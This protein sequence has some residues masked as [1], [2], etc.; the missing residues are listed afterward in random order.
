M[1]KTNLQR[2]IFAAV[3][4]LYPYSVSLIDLTAEEDLSTPPVC[5]PRDVSNYVSCVITNC[6]T[7]P[8]TC[9]IDQCLHILGPLS[10]EC[11]LC[12]LIN[13]D[14]GTGITRCTTEPETNYERSFGLMLLSRRKI[15]SSRAEG[16]LGNVSQ[17]RGFYQASVSLESC[18]LSA[19]SPPSLLRKI[20]CVMGGENFCQFFF[21]FDRLQK[22]VKYIVPICPPH[23]EIAVITVI[24]V[25]ITLCALLHI[26]YLMGGRVGRLLAL[27]EEFSC[28]EI[29]HVTLT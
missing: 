1:W 27:V 20:N 16:Y 21:L 24:K 8:R 19:P 10:T 29:D 18:S 2:E 17:I 3:K 15:S 22:L 26:L 11:A 14:T 5:T 25:E 12:M 28:T 9:I 6:L 13:I 23:M 7:S 4:D